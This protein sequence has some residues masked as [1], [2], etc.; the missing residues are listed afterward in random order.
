M[1][2][3]LTA[4]AFV[5]CF[6]R[7]QAQPGVILVPTS[8]F[9]GDAVTLAPTGEATLL[10]AADTAYVFRRSGFEWALEAVLS[11]DGAII[12]D[13]FG[14]GVALAGPPGEEVAVVGATRDDEAGEK[15]GA[16]YVFRRTPDG[17]WLEEAKLLP[18]D[19]HPPDPFGNGGAFGT[20]VALSASG[21]VAVIG[22]RVP[23]NAGGG[24]PLPNTVYV[25]RHTAEGTWVEEAQL[26]QAEPEDDLFFAYSLDVAPSGT[27]VVVGSVRQNRN[28]P[29]AGLVTIFRR[30]GEEW[31]EE[32][33][34][35]GQ[36]FQ[37]TFGA[38][39]SIIDA[40]DETEGMALVGCNE[41]DLSGVGRTGAAFTYHKASEGEP[42]MQE[43]VLYGN[44]PQNFGDFGRLVELAGSAA[45]IGGL[46]ASVQGVHAFLR[47]AEGG[48][49]EIRLLLPLYEGFGR[50]IAL[51]TPEDFN[52]AT[53]LVGAEG[54]AYVYDFPLTVATEPPSASLSFA[55]E[56]WPNPFRDGLNVAL[57]SKVPERVRVEVFNVLG[58]LVWANEVQSD[59]GEA[60]VIRLDGERLVSGTYFVRV[61]GSHGGQAVRQAVR[62]E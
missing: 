48:W 50:G 60:T 41:C 9:S 5:L 23:G 21:E 4:L 17:T 52:E 12:G 26:E 38:S 29:D 22:T 45:G 34:L 19:P 54:R 11:A 44:D 62:V 53:A 25:F 61:I 32:A 28:G 2:I 37:H 1:R 6:S 13:E 33:V 15:A 8:E 59:P 51:A 56:T 31:G 30:I 3:L 20:N 57:T 24:V 42:W 36:P 18:S 27:R 40:L 47:T 58:R 7:S 46:V 16:A 14:Y 49:T 43:T 35:M 55:V 39:V 10:G